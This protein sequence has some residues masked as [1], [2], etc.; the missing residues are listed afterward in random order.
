MLVLHKKKLQELLEELMQLLTIYV[1]YQLFGI[2]ALVAKVERYS[3]YSVP[4]HFFLNI[5]ETFFCLRMI[6]IKL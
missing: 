5:S 1:K 6:I 2:A 3:G 4:D